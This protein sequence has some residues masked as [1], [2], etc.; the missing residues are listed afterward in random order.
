MREEVQVQKEQTP[1][2]ELIWDFEVLKLC[3]MKLFYIAPFW[4]QEP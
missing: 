2:D 3:S 1:G 4:S